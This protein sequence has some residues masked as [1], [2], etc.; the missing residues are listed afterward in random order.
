MPIVDLVIS[1]FLRAT[2][3]LL[4]SPVALAAFYVRAMWE[5]MKSGW[6]MLEDVFNDV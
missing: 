6:Y 2:A 5:G 1:S 3:L 4:A